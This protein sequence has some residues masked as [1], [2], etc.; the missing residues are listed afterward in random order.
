MVQSIGQQRV[1][2]DLATTNN[3][4]VQQERQLLLLLI[5]VVINMSL[6]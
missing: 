3:H 1:G 6:E 2:H 5:A 4:K